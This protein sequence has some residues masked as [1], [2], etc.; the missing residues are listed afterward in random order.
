MKIQPLGDRVVIEPLDE[1]GGKT[2]AGIYLPETSEKERPQEGKV[3]AVGS[4]KV[5]DDGKKIPMTVK[6]GDHVLFTKYGPTEI[7]VDGKEYLIARE[8]DILGIIE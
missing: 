1:K 6:K 5:S 4:G 7:K 2:K 8:D 3:V